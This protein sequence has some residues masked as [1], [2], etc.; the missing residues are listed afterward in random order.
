MFLALLFTG[1]YSFLNLRYR[2]YQLQHTET[3]QAFMIHR[4]RI[5]LLT[6]P[7]YIIHMFNL[8]RVCFYPNH[9]RP[10]ETRNKL[11]NILVEKLPYFTSVTFS[12][13]EVLMLFEDSQLPQFSLFNYTST[14]DFLSF[15][16][17]LSCYIL[18]IGNK[19][20]TG[21]SA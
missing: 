2:E 10:R 6:S 17:I 4:S 13:Y 1:N 21:L 14:S 9:Y 3:F 18:G 15:V 20:S 7:F 19:N 12:G 5:G 8:K 16:L 11:D